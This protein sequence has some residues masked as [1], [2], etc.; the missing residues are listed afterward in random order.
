MKK[1]ISYEVII[2]ETAH[3]VEVK[4][5]GCKVPIFGAWDT[6]PY[7]IAEAWRAVA[8]A[9]LEEAHGQQYREAFNPP[10]YD[11]TYRQYQFNQLKDEHRNIFEEITA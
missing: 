2:D 7:T 11:S 4:R 9:A 6:S 8:D 3:T 5:Q 10:V 1:A